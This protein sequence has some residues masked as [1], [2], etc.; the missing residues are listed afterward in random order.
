M[1]LINVCEMAR[2]DVNCRPCSKSTTRTRWAESSPL[3]KLLD[4]H[5]IVTT[6]QRKHL[7]VFLQNFVQRIWQNDL[8]ISPS[9]SLV[10]NHSALD[11]SCEE[12]RIRATAV[13]VSHVIRGFVLISSPA[14]QHLHV[15]RFIA[16]LRLTLWY[17]TSC[18]DNNDS[19]SSSNNN[20][21]NNTNLV[22][23]CKN[24]CLQP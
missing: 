21:N 13:Q 19:S 23:L 24:T 20:N 12:D 17:V 15:A 22:M 18:P 16:S 5:G 9:A 4:H 11:G 6:C 1:W 14:W 8:W 3:F 2:P 7:T 10:L